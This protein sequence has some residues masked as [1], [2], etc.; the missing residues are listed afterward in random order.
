MWRRNEKSALVSIFTTAGTGEK[1]A[2]DFIMSRIRA[3]RDE[4]NDEP[5]D[6]Q[7]HREGDL[8]PQVVREHQLLYSSKNF[9]SKPAARPNVEPGS[10]CRIHLKQAWY[11]AARA[12]RCPCRT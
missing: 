9:P 3:G 10:E 6:R 5:W 12:S 11:Q 8:Q 4:L 7:R 2:P 1:A